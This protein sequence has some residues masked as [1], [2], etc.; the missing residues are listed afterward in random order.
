MLAFPTIVGFCSFLLAV[1][2]YALLGLKKCLGTLSPCRFHAYVTQLPTEN[3]F[4]KL[5]SLETYFIVSLYTHGQRHNYADGATL[6]T[7]FIL[8][9]CLLYCHMLI[10]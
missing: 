2:G 6:L 9:L 7:I 8:A 10:V 4:V 5:V 3:T 1:M